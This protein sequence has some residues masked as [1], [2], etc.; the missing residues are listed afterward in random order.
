MLAIES[1]CPICGH[2]HQ[3]VVHYALARCK[4]G[5]TYKTDFKQDIY[6]KKARQL[7]SLLAFNDE[8]EIIASEKFEGDI[9]HIQKHF[10]L[11]HSWEVSE[12]TNSKEEYRKCKKCGVC[13][14][15]ITCKGCGKTYKRNPSRKKQRCPTC[16][17]YNYTT[18]FF[19]DVFI[20]DENKNI[21]LC[22]YCN[23]DNI[24]M[25]RVTNKTKC[26]ICGSRK[27]TDK[28]TNI[29]YKLTIKR[30]RAYMIENA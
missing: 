14:D 25:T 27:L 8:V 24:R 22:P 18:T 3:C 7:L 4:C 29:L 19:K 15:C 30:K 1:K 23:S 21:K 13:L 6:T 11:M 5:A 28:R 26:H 10:Q 2:T 12:I 16:Q 20:R 9:I 17:S